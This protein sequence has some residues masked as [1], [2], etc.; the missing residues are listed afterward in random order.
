M[1]FDNF[2]VNVVSFNETGGVDWTQ[3]RPS[4]ALTITPNTGYAINAANFSPINPLPNYVDSVTCSH[5]GTNIECTILYTT[6]SVCLVT[7]C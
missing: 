5:S 6:P 7:M 3:S 2:T 1:A 4:V